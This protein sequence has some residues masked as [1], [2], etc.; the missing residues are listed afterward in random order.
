MNGAPAV[1]TAP[2]IDAGRLPV[3]DG[4]VLAWRRFGAGAA[5]GVPVWLALHG[6]PGSASSPAL[7]A[8]FDLRR[9]HVVLFDQRGCGASTPAG[10]ITANDITTLADD[11]ERLRTHLGVARW[12]LV[13]G[14]WGATLALATVARHPHAVQALLL[15]N[16]F[17]PDSSELQWFFGG[18]RRLAPHAWEALAA[19]APAAR[20]DALLPWLAEVFAGHDDALQARTARAWLAWERALAGLPAQPPPA[21]AALQAAVLRYRVQAHVLEA[22]GGLHDGAVAAFAAACP[23]VPAWVLHGAQDRVCRPEAARAV[24]A[25]LRGS[26]WQLVA[27]AGH[28]PFHPAMARALRKAVADLRGRAAGPEHAS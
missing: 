4:H 7:L 1:D 13:A 23:Q 2:C 24:Q 10:G 8:P 22:L 19:L 12:T 21:G 17:V 6:G 3:G 9:D 15:R 16:L 25:R 26:R 28:D 14:S 11:V 18:A 5:A 20:R 27:G